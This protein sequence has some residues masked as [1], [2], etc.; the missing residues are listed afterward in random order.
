MPCE[1]TPRKFEPTSDEAVIDALCAGTPAAVKIA[2][3]NR[4]RVST[5]IRGMKL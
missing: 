5:G 2:S 4:V 3:T 1:S